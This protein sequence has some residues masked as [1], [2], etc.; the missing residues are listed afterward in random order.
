MLTHDLKQACLFNHKGA[1]TVSDMLSKLGVLAR[2]AEYID[3]SDTKESALLRTCLSRIITHALSDKEAPESNGVQHKK[4]SAQL[5]ANARSLA[6]NALRSL[7]TCTSF[8]AISRLR[9]TSRASTRS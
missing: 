9:A 2:A 8:F 6:A 7:A 5:F 1:P 4:A 3:L